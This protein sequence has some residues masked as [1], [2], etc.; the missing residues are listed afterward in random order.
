MEADRGGPQAWAVDRREC[1]RRGRARA[2]GAH[3]GRRR[4]AAIRGMPEHRAE[5]RAF[6]GNARGRKTA[7][8]PLAEDRRRG[9]AFDLALDAATRRTPSPPGCPAP[10]SSENLTMKPTASQRR[11]S[12]PDWQPRSSATPR[13]RRALGRVEQAIAEI[14]G[15]SCQRSHR[16]SPALARAGRDRPRRTEILIP[17]GRSASFSDQPDLGR[18]QRDARRV[19]GSLDAFPRRAQTLEQ[20]A[21]AC[22]R[23]SVCPNGR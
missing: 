3:W 5:H 7:T 1:A 22:P 9:R 19:R 10:P 4:S 16:Q 15:R 2:A 21:G 12:A 17:S 6:A 14:I 20:E 11:P 8:A 18:S 13:R 23:R